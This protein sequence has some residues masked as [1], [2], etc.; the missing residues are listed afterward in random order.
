MPFMT[1]LLFTQPILEA[2][3]QEEAVASYAGNYVVASLPNLYIVAI[4]DMTKRW[5]GAMRVTWIT[6]VG[7]V[8]ATCLHFAW[9]QLF[10]I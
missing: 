2:I 4:L 5:L 9:L 6:M 1:V 7:Q 10:V 8:I 3:G